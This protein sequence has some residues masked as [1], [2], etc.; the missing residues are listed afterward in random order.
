MVAWLPLPPLLQVFFPVPKI[1]LDDPVA[2]F[3]SRIGAV[4]DYPAGPTRRSRLQHAII[5]LPGLKLVVLHSKERRER[6]LD[7]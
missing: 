7:Q 1:E 4:L 6:K 2:C 5:P 3:Y